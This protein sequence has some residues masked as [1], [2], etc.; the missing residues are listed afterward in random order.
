MLAQREFRDKCRMCEEI[1]D[2]P[3][4]KPALL[5]NHFKVITFLSKYH[6]EVRMAEMCNYLGQDG[7]MEISEVVAIAAYNLDIVRS[8]DG[9]SLGC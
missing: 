2:K 6:D 1:G 7:G 4:S 5:A 9:F 8:I 3:P